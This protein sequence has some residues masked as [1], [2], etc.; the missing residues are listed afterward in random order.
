[1]GFTVQHPN[2]TFS[3]RMATVSHYQASGQQSVEIL[4][5]EPLQYNVDTALKLQI[6]V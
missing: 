6:H 1:M 4:V 3:D 2:E 5:N